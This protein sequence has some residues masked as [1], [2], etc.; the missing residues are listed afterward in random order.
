VGSDLARGTLKKRQGQLVD[1]DL[2]RVRGM[3]GASR[4][5]LVSKAGLSG[6]RLG[7]GA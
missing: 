6:T 2:A 3:A 7:D 4:D 1:V 5:Y